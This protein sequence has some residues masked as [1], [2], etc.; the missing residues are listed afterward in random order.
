VNPLVA[1]LLGWAFANETISAIQLLALAL[2]LTGV[3]FVNIP[4]Y[5]NRYGV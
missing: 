4:K 1:T 3:L 5:L 2:I